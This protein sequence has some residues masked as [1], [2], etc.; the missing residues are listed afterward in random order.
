MVSKREAAEPA[1]PVKV[2]EEVVPEVP[3]EATTYAS[4]NFNHKLFQQRHTTTTEYLEDVSSTVVT[5]T[6][7][8]IAKVTDEAVQIAKDMGIPPWGLAAIVILVLTIVLGIVGFCIRRCCK[9]RR[10]KDGKG[11]KGVD[12][13]SVQLL[14]SAYKE[15]VRA[16]VGNRGCVGGKIL[17]HSIFLSLCVSVPSFANSLSHTLSW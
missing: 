9:K 11:K 8:E 17:T 10:S 3:I 7:G 5:P 12:L 6:K 1:S 13:K 14:G 4:A 15:K 16:R 2:A